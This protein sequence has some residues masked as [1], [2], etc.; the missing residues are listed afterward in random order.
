MARKK[1]P[2]RR[3]RVSADHLKDVSGKVTPASEA[4]K[5]FASVSSRIYKP[6]ELRVY[7]EKLISYERP[8]WTPDEFFGYTGIESAGELIYNSAF[9]RAAARLGFVFFIGSDGR[10][11]RHTVAGGGGGDTTPAPAVVAQQAGEIDE[12]YFVKPLWYDDLATFVEAGSPTLLI[13]PPGVGKTEACERIF[14]ERDQRLH[15]ISCNP[16]MTSDD[17]EGRIELRNEEGATVTSFEPGTMTVASKD[18]HGVLLD[19]A[20]AIPAT[21]A[22]GVFRLLAG[23]DMRILRMGSDGLIPRHDNFRIVG[24]QNTEG[25][26]DDRGLHHGRA[27]QDEAFLDR[28]ENVIRVDYPLKTVEVDILVKKTGVSA[29]D[30]DRI[31]QAAVLLRKALNEDAIMF[32]CSMRRTLA[33]ARNLVRGHAPEKSWHFAVVNRAT[34]EDA[35]GIV[36]ILNRVY[37]G[38]FG[39]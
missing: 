2:A 24:T 39:R 35:K 8:T 19:E 11:Y 18:G 7:V 25:R 4:D 20:D 9:I 15:I 30:A 29:D 34:R 6:E 31:V 38:K 17:L 26:G 22:F 36:E 3:A 27:Y 21:A 23:K 12:D 5:Y 16:S 14:A 37:G 10:V 32:C 13:G 28:W 1:R 33:V